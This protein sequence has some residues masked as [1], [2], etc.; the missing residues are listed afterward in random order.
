MAEVVVNKITGEVIEE[1]NTQD[2]SLIPAFEATS[3]FTPST[4]V[5][6]FS[7]Y[8]E[9]GLL[10]YINPNYKGYT[11]TLNYSSQ[12]NSVSTVTVDPEKDL[13]KEGYEQGNYTVY[14]NFLRNVAS[15]SPKTPYFLTQV[16]S[17][18]TEVRLAINS[19][20]NEELEQTVT[21]FQNE[22]N[23]SPY[24]EDFRLNFGNNNVF[25]ATN[26]LLDTSK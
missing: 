3:Q 20:T 23:D 2:L 18:R 14:Y 1:Y 19:L 16:S 21:S 25:I 12:K 7:I 10:E 26:I 8:N 22:L 13:I 9:Q 17:D 6:E 24:F 15:S 5:V 11:V 4:D